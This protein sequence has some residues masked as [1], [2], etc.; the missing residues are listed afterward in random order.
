MKLATKTEIIPSLDASIAEV[1]KLAANIQSRHRKNCHEAVLAGMHLAHIK[2]QFGMQHGGDRRSLS[3]AEEAKKSFASVLEETGV[4]RKSAY[5]WIGKAQEL[6]SVLGILSED[7]D[8]PEPFPSPGTAE[9]NRIAAAAER[10]A[11]NTSMDR[12]Q[13]GGTGDDPDEQ[14]LE[15]LMTQAEAGDPEALRWI[16]RWRAGE[17]T[18]ARA[19]C[20]YGGA[21]AT[22]GKERKDPVYLDFDLTK[23]QPVG[24]IPKA[25][26][27]LRN[28]F[29]HWESYDEDARQ[30]VLGMW[31]EAMK[32]A[33][34]ELIE[35]IRK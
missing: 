23:K 34:R 19:V 6:A 17:I 14:R 22:K 31:R 2:D 35:I 3:Y 18:L 33:P 9:W 1:R 20:A 7:P 26:T 4:P 15:H 11:Q 24:L 29:E 10:W 32:K 28:G 12:L 5:R 8:A 21:E 13:V 30:Q 16:D 27:T 25:F